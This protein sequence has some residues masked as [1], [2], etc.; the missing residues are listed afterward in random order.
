MGT[1]TCASIGGGTRGLVNASG[2]III[3]ASTTTPRSAARADA[4]GGAILGSVQ[5]NR[6]IAR[7]T[8]STTARAADVD[9]IAGETA[10]ARI[11]ACSLSAEDASSSGK[12]IGLSAGIGSMDATATLIP[13]DALAELGAGAKIGA[14]HEG[15][16][17]LSYDAAGR[18]QIGA[19]SIGLGSSPPSACRGR[20][21]R[22]ADRS[23]RRSPSSRRPRGY[24]H[25][26][27]CRRLHANDSV[28]YQRPTN[29][30]EGD[31]S[32]SGA[33]VGFAAIGDT[34]LSHNVSQ[35]R[36]TPI[37][38]GARL[39][40]NSTGTITISARGGMDA[41]PPRNYTVVADGVVA[42]SD[43]LVITG[44]GLKTGDIIQLGT[45]G[46]TFGGVATGRILPILRL[47]DNTVMFGRDVAGSRVDAARDT[48]S[49]EA[50]HFLRTGDRVN[51]GPAGSASV[52]YW[53]YVLDDTTIKLLDFDPNTISG[54]LRLAGKDASTQTWIS[55]ANDTITINNHGFN[56]G[57][58][59]TYRAAPTQASF[60]SGDVDVSISGN[61]PERQAPL[62][63]QC[64]AEPDLHPLPGHRFSTRPTR[65]LYTVTGGAA[66]TGYV[67]GTVYQIVRV[68]ENFIQ[69]KPQAGGSVV[70]PV[71]AD[72]GNLNARHTLTR[73]GSGPV[74]GLSDGTVYRVQRIDANTIKLKTLA[75]TVV[76][77]DRR[78]ASA[79]HTL[80]RDGVNLGAVTATQRITLDLQ[81]GGTTTLLGVG[82]VPLDTI[83]ADTGDGV[84]RVTADGLVIGA[85]A[86]SD[87]RAVANITS[88][89]RAI[90]DRRARPSTRPA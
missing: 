64:G 34:K 5:A 44:H 52:T 3:E 50:P 30:A 23:T 77:P 59:V 58:L 54:I 53:A 42:S 57:D 49:F 16:G 76:N 6:A 33:S 38:G 19:N 48:I 41:A 79:W 25:R 8:G 51:Y 65:H 18:I 4:P 9:L 68:D 40:A 2:D 75:G 15:D 21:C 72:L 84:S 88:T 78:P 70:A 7:S 69:L 43:R 28:R 45:E 60:G 63:R 80:V 13:C 90:V 11:A 22:Q 24:A 1:V 20:P 35:T 61:K 12:S 56:E 73:V 46:S 66:L 47:D 67:A 83:I 31:A 27:Q 81:A 74:A 36:E 37:G 26:R 17:T 14:A 87:N 85:I 89:V 62:R 82:G 29:R 86:G 55:A 10:L 39:R 71:D 32:L